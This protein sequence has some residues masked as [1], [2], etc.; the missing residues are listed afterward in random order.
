MA[1]NEMSDGAEGLLAKK[2]KARS[3][4]AKKSPPSFK[5]TPASKPKAPVKAAKKKATPVAKKKEE[6]PKARPSAPKAAFKVPAAGTPLSPSSTKKV[7][8]SGFSKA[9]GMS[10]RAATKAAAARIAASRPGKPKNSDDKDKQKTTAE[11]Y[12]KKNKL[13]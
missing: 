6:A 3:D 11:N 13:Y 4:A 5:G 9:Q 10:N 8:E 12:L 2:Y 1:K 7:E